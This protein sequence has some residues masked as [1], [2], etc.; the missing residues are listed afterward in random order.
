MCIR[1]SRREVP[2]KPGRVTG[3]TEEFQQLN[4]ASPRMQLLQ[5]GE[6]TLA[7][8]DTGASVSK[9]RGLDLTRRP[10]DLLRRPLGIFAFIKTGDETFSVT[11]APL[12]RGR[13]SHRVEFA[14]SYTAF[15]AKKGEVEAGMMAA[16]HP[17]MAVSYTHLEEDKPAAVPEMSAAQ[18]SPSRRI[19]PRLPGLRRQSSGTGRWRC[20]A[21]R[22]C[23]A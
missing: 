3:T 18:P 5:N 6:W 2:Q 12:Y 20:A 23:A 1:D 19:R 11:K 21:A 22:R 9:Y 13:A 7:I 15:Y 8:T 10:F 17:R 14:P 16:L 4:P